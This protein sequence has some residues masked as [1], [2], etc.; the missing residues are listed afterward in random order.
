MCEKGE[1]KMA[2]FDEIEIGKI[3]LGEPNVRK[4]DVDLGIDELAKSIEEQG[5]LQPII[6]HK[7]NGNYELIAGQRRLTALIKLGRKTVPAMI[8]DTSDPNTMM[9]I[10]LIENIQRVDIDERDR[11]A[12][13]EKLV[14]ANNGDYA[15]VAKMLGK[16]EG[17]IRSYSGYHGVPDEL[18]TLKEKQIFDRSQVISLTRMLGPDK[19]VEVGKEISTFP[20]RERERALRGIRKYTA[21]QP[22]EV[23]S[24]AKSETTEK[25][26]TIRFMS[27]IMTALERAAAD[28]DESP[29][30]T[31]HYIV[32]EW[33]EKRNYIKVGTE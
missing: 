13:I 23:I 27:S 31:I 25:Q 28:R 16:S 19:A 30:D 15:A 12:A 3:A 11:A 8:V 2:K 1:G 24:W 5:L 33:L 22:E 4:I 7:I 32:R 26:L 14:D 20:K 10:S 17:T 6:V 21:L 29:T 18:K 9:L